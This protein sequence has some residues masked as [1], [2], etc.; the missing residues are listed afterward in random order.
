MKVGQKNKEHC[1]RCIVEELRI[2][3]EI[4]SNMNSIP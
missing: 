2:K 3:A 4:Y 1:H